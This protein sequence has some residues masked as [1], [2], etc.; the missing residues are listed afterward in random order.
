MSNIIIPGHKKRF[1]GYLDDRGV[2]H[3]KPYLTDW[4]IQKCEQMP[5]CRGIFDPF[6]AHDKA[7][8]A[9]KCRMKLQE[10]QYHEKKIN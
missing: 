8:A 9:L 2:I 4:D 3:I 5:F 10:L 6:E 7:E 1:W